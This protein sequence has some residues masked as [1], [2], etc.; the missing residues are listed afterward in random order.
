ME[1]RGFN[2]GEKKYF[3]GEIPSCARNCILEELEEKENG[4]GIIVNNEEK[5]YEAIS[6]D[7]ISRIFV[8]D[9]LKIKIEAYNKHGKKHLIEIEGLAMIT[10]EHLIFLRKLGN[11]Y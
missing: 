4:H 1:Y 10:P 2:S 3:W 7:A 9:E 5:T 6:I 11:R 8:D